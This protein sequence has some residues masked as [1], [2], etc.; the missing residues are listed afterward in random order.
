MKCCLYIVEFEV[1]LALWEL[2]IW[3]FGMICQLTLIPYL[4]FYRYEQ[5]IEKTK[6]L[7]QRSY[8]LTNNVAV[9]AAA[10]QASTVR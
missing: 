8:T 2:P 10:V 5:I 7:G 6:L 4:W 3:R 1:I 9:T